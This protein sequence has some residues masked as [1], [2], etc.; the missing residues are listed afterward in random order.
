MLAELDVKGKIALF[1]RGFKKT[2]IKSYKRDYDLTSFMTASNATIQSM[3]E[4]LGL[5][6]VK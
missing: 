3:T 1:E 5:I 2:V 6:V 4:K